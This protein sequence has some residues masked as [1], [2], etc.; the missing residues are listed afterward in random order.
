MGA[1]DRLK[2]DDEA[3]LA[4]ESEGFLFLSDTEVVRGAIPEVV[5]LIEGV[6]AL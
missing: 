2:D 1:V 5:L 3:L 6:F 4:D